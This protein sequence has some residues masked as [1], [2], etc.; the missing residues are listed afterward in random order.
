MLVASPCLSLQR[1]LSGALEA[2]RG[3][4]AEL[5]QRIAEQGLEA[6]VSACNCM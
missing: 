5:G 3:V 2:I 1:Q 6:E 4:L